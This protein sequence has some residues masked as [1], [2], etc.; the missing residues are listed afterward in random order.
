MTTT[1]TGTDRAELLAEV[2]R[3]DREVTRWAGAASAKRAAAASL[4]VRVGD[5]LLADPENGSGVT[6]KVR[7]L[8]D[9]AAD[10]EQ[11]ATAAEAKVALGWAAVLEHDAQRWEAEADGLELV[12]AEHRVKT[13]RLLNQLRK[14]E[15]EF[16]PK[17][18]LEL[19]PGGTTYLS[20]FPVRS[21]ELQRDVER[22]RLRA[23]VLRDLVAG[24]NPK[25][26]ADRYDN[27]PDGR[28]AKLADNR[29]GM[30]LGLPI[31]EYMP[32]MSSPDLATPQRVRARDVEVLEGRLRQ[33]DYDVEKA[34]AT[35]R[36]KR[37]LI[38]SLQAEIQSRQ[39]TRQRTAIPDEQSRM[40]SLSS[41]IHE[42]EQELETAPDR[43]AE[44][45]AEL[46]SLGDGT[47]GA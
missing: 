3:W 17:Q 25:A 22:A 18:E 26:H 2:T 31:A 32:D 40:S 37:A 39:N 47:D 21:S 11:A 45:V 46:E 20:S 12:L 6:S 28:L 42:L 10:A 1:T 13:D 16:T 14:H 33:H 38:A 23:A 24:H 9:A 15:G 44:I 35:L 36:D 4:R 19:S 7:E 34:E 29:D 8:D 5:A 30:V 43:R 27:G 41:W